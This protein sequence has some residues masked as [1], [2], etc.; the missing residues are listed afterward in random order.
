MPT[1]PET[2]QNYCRSISLCFQKQTASLN[3]TENAANT[4]SL[5]SV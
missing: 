4:S 3:G 2:T 1:F 5:K